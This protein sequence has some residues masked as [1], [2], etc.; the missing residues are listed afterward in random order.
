MTPPALQLQAGPPLQ[1]KKGPAIQREEKDEKK[2]KT[3]PSD[4]QHDFSLLPPE[5]QLKLWYLSMNA[6]TSSAD[7]NF[8]KDQLHLGLGYEYGKS[9]SLGGS[10]GDF[11]GKYSIDP[12]NA[13]MKGSLNW[14]DHLKATGS[15]SPG[16]GGFDMGLSGKH[17]GFSGSLSGGNKG[18]NLGMGYDKFKLSG[19]ADFAK[20]SAGASF[21]YGGPLAPMPW[22][23]GTS[24]NGGVAGM[25]GAMG[26]LGGLSGDPS[27]WMDH[28]KGQEG[29]ID[30][31]TKAGK[32]LYGLGKMGSPLPFAAG[33][34]F[35]ISP[36]MGLM[37]M[38]QA[39]GHF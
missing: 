29:N 28:Y 34:K 21:S 5:L 6:D 39:Q 20:K 4:F 30:A 13:D 9:L 16:S 3:E 18:L 12:S 37:L 25:H 2:K 32:G 17:Q 27:Q 22:D 24:V 36:E 7:L 35:S 26:S 15:Y 1:K 23:L 33:G 14:G 31:M 19:N 8:D 11:G 38:L 10:Y